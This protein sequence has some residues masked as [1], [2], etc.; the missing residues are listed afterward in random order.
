MSLSFPNLSRSYDQS[1]RC[2]RFWAYDEVLE[3]SFFVDADAFCRAEALAQPNE[4][5]ILDA[6]D[7][8][9]DGIC[10][11]AKRIYTRRGKASYTLTAA[12]CQ[13]AGGQ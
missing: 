9:R 6:F 5:S 10:A 2:V 3:I 1:R 7:L 13:L 8:N 4:K 11:A 12:D